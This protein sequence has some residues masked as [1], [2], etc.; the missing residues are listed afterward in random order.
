LEQF[1]VD[2]CKQ[3]SVKAHI[4]HRKNGVYFGP[5]EMSLAGDLENEDESTSE[6]IFQLQIKKTAC[7]YILFYTGRK[8]E[9]ALVIII[10]TFE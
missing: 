3:Q 10:H 8:D 5:E 6:V 1:L 7:T 4:D 9:I 2:I